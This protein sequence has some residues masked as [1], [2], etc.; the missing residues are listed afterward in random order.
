MA[1][2]KIFLDPGK[3]IPKFSTK[4]WRNFRKMLR[5]SG[6]SSKLREKIYEKLQLCVE[7]CK[8]VSIL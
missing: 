5:K 4:K 7:R 3:L 2:S 6:N 8:N 1:I